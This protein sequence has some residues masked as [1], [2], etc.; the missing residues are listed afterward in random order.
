ARQPASTTYESELQRMTGTDGQ[1]TFHA[2]VLSLFQETI[3]DSVIPVTDGAQIIV[4]NRETQVTELQLEKV[5]KE[6]ESLG[7]RVLRYTNTKPGTDLLRIQSSTGFMDAHDTFNALGGRI[8]S[9][10][11]SLFSV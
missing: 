3:P 2:H 10:V 9:L 6:L 11:N 4:R 1:T 5:K 7:L 8:A